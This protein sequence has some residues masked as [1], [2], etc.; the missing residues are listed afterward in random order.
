M[1]EEIKK[2]RPI[3]LREAIQQL[4]RLCRPAIRT[5]IAISEVRIL[6]QRCLLMLIISAAADSDQTYDFDAGGEIEYLGVKMQRKQGL[7]FTCLTDH[8]EYLGVNQLLIY[9]TNPLSKS[10]VGL[11]VNS[12][13][14]DSAFKA[15]TTLA[16]SMVHEKPIDYLVDPKV[17]AQNWKYETKLPTNIINRKYTTIHS[18]EW[19]RRWFAQ[20]APECFLRGDKLPEVIYSS[21][22]TNRR[23]CTGWKVSANGY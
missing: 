4:R 3:L 19:T 21:I 8:S 15:Y 7:D 1:V 9:T 6:T 5:K 17:I 2:P 14:K 12:G 20:H 22:P 13:N 18:Y 11:L 10:P 16:L 23:T